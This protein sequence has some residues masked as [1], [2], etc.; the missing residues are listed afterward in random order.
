MTVVEELR[1]NHKSL[2]EIG[3]LSDVS[4]LL[5]AADLL[6]RYESALREIES[7]SLCKVIARANE[8]AVID[9]SCPTCI[10]RKALAAG[11]GET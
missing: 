10:A 1:A 9:K 7:E 2:L 3:F 4:L 5:R 11:G 8:G 6:Q